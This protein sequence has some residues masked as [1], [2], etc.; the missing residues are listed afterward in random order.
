MYGGLFPQSY[1]NLIGL[2]PW[3]WNVGYIKKMVEHGWIKLWK[4]YGGFPYEL[5][6]THHSWMVY[7]RENPNLK[8]MITRGTPILGHPHIR[9]KK[10][11]LMK[12]YKTSRMIQKKEKLPIWSWWCHVSTNLLWKLLQCSG[13]PSQIYGFQTCLRSDVRLSINGDTHKIHRLY[14]KIPKNTLMV[15]EYPYFRKPQCE[16]S[17]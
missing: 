2:H 5:A 8:W 14:W 16:D 10:T 15:L 9:K 4:K 3:S 17:G 11:H 1:A 6:A 13:K 12:A 7:S